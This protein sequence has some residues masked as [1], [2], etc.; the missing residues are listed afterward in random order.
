MVSSREKLLRLEEE[1]NLKFLERD[2]LIRVI[3]LS[4]LTRQHTLIFGKHGAAKSNLIQSVAEAI[5]VK[6]FRVQLGKDT[7]S[8]QVFGPIKVSQLANDKLCRAYTNFL[9]GCPIAFLD[10]VDKANSLILNSLYTV[11]EE[12]LFADDG[13]MRPTPLV[14]LFGAANSIAQLQTDQLAPLLDRFLFRVEVDWIQ[15]DSNFLEFIRRKAEDDTPILTNTLTLLEL[16][17]MQVQVKQISFCR[18][19]QETVARLRKELAI[20][21]VLVS[22]RRWGYSVQ[23][24]K[25]AAFIDG[26]Q[27]VDESHFLAL[28]DV[29]WTNKNQ[30]STIETKL[31]ALN[32]G[33]PA[34]VQQTI[35]AIESRVATV[36]ANRDRASVSGQAA[37]LLTDLR[38][39]E[40]QIAQLPTNSSVRTARASVQNAIN[41]VQAHRAEICS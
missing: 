38:G 3:L 9:P 18:S 12:R 5:A 36:M 11:M 27:E 34:P 29:L 24:L 25:A 1:L 15:S 39:L 32:Q 4:L 10:E 2:Q 8:D 6:C 17:E 14:S 26:D 7:S 22:D 41:Q 13:Q 16:Q 40:R 33:L 35:R 28:R 30:I 23:V 20:E 31:R 21:G 37:L 19:A